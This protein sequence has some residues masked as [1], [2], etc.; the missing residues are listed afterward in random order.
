MPVIN[1]GFRGAIFRTL[2]SKVKSTLLEA[3]QYTLRTLSAT[4]NQTTRH[5]NKLCKGS[6]C[7]HTHLVSTP[8]RKEDL[9]AMLRATFESICMNLQV[10]NPFETYHLQKFTIFSKTPEEQIEFF[11]NVQT[12]IS[13][14]TSKNKTPRSS[15]KEKNLYLS[16]NLCLLETLEIEIAQTINNLK[17]TDIWLNLKPKLISVSVAVVVC[18]G[19][20]CKK[21]ITF[22]DNTTAF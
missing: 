7:I 10:E 16:C 15:D 13:N 14:F 6:A 8:R 18:I 19:I 2:P 9:V 3:E 22:N 12:I 17:C 20:L 4:I 5:S 11:Q 1:K 21:E